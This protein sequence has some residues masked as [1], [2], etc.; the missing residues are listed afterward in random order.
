M[1]G[2]GVQKDFNKAISLYQQ[3]SDLGKAEAQLGLGIFYSTGMFSKKR[4]ES[5]S[6]KI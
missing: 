5:R 1:N 3:S 6:K 2:Q 4:K